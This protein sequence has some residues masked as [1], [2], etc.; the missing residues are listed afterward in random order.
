MPAKANDTSETDY[1][2]GNRKKMYTFSHSATEQTGALTDYRYIGYYGANQKKLCNINAEVWRMLGV[3]T[4]D[5]ENG[6]QEQG[7]K[8]VKDNPLP[9]KMN[10]CSNNLNDWSTAKLNIYLNGYNY[11]NFKRGTTVY[12]G[13]ST[14][15]TGKVTLMHSSDLIYM[16]VLG[17]MDS[18]YN[19]CLNVCSGNRTCF[20]YN[21]YSHSWFMSFFSNSNDVFSVYINVGGTINLNMFIQFYIY[22]RKSKYSQVMDQ[23]H[24]H[25]N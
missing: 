17:V 2:A 4:V 21:S 12:S 19:E 20:N 23:R 15:C 3:F 1:N 7:I 18:Y 16:S 14:S 5:D 13:H 6:K 22:Y 25:I 24:V 8:I 9:N 10:W 11:Y